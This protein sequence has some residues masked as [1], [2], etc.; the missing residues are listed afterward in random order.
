V[1]ERLIAVQ[2]RARTLGL[3]QDVG[4]TDPAYIHVLA[5]KGLLPGLPAPAEAEPW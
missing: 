2:Q 3:F 1:R 5:A 4:V